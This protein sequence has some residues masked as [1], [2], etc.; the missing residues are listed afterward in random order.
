M[1]WEWVQS[2][3]IDNL[4]LDRVDFIKVDAQGFEA[5]VLKGG[6]ETI[7]KFLP[8]IYFKESN[9]PLQTPAYGRHLSPSFEDALKPLGYECFFH[10]APSGPPHL[11]HISSACAIATH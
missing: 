10:D 1:T 9:A 3:T 6:T 5:R 11:P 7:K 2:I 4:Q 8:V